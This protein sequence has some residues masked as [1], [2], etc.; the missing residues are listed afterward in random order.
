MLKRLVILAAVILAVVAGGAGLVRMMD[1]SA[2]AFRVEGEVLHIAGPISGAAADRLQR[3]LEQTPGLETVVLGGMPGADDVSWAVQMGAMIRAVGL[4][5]QAEGAVVNDAILLF[6]GG[7]E[8]RMAGGVLA[9]Q[10]DTVQRQLGVAVDNSTAAEAD[11]IRFIE[12]MLG[13]AGFAGFMAETRAARDTY[14]LT[15]DDLAR[16]GLTTAN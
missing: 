4:D 13:D 10:S 11:R 1:A 6:L 3:T 12:A 16:F 5:T 15:G 7:T 9:L 2:T 8:R 14:E